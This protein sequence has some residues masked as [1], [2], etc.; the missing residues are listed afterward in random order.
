MCLTS[1]RPSGKAR[2]PS[3]TDPA[4]VANTVAKPL[5]R[6]RRTPTTLEYRPSPRPATDGHGRCE[7]PRRVRRLHLVRRK[8]ESWDVDRATIRRSCVSGRSGWSPRCGRTTR[9]T[10]RRSGGG[11]EAG[12]R[13]RGDAAQVG[14]PGR[15]RRRHTAWGDQRG[16]RGARRLRARGAEL[17]RANEILKAASAFFAAELD[18]PQRYS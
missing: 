6:A 13:Q 17:R 2:R 11:R 9:R 16:V 10:G 4:N 5:D 12:H 3:R 18:R 7:S 14:P 1:A 8:M 15:G